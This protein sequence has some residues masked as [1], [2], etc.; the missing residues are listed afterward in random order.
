MLEDNEFTDGGSVPQADG[1]DETGAESANLPM[2][3]AN[4]AIRRLQGENAELKDRHLR[5]AAEFD[6]FRK[7]AARERIELGDRAQATLVT[8]LLDVLDDFDR[9]TAGGVS[10]AS[11]DDLRQVLSLID[12]KLRKELEAGGLERIDPNGKP[13]DPALHEA[14]SVLAPALP[15]QDHTVANTF[16]AGYKYKGSL[17]RPARV[18]VYSSEG[19]A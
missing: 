14:V 18:Q 9:V 12:K 1:A 8:R 16:Q 7:R 11:A 2:E 10:G 5:L 3:P 19:H 13:F 6:N 4:E 15:E 17:I